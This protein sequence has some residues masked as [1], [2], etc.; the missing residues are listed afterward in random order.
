ML[1]ALL[2]ILAV[3]AVLWILALPDIR[4]SHEFYRRVLEHSEC[5][6]CHGEGGVWAL[7]DGE[8]IFIGCTGGAP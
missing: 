6:R 7:I 8:L 1:A 3:F 2:L 4:A 5:E